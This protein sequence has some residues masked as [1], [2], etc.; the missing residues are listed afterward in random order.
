VKSAKALKEFT[1]RRNRTALTALLALGCGLAIAGLAF[2]HSTRH[3]GPAPPTGPVLET[4]REVAARVASLNGDAHP[5]KAIAVPS[6]RKAANALD[7]GAEVDTDQLSYLIV[8]HGNFVGRVAHVPRGAPLPRGSV[9]TI[10]VDADTGLVTDWG[11]SDRTPDTSSLGP[12]T[13][14]GNF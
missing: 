11:I 9:L 1:K 5:T 7:S 2:G 10:I 3:A 8:L 6:T 4:L 14:L 13:S 12:E